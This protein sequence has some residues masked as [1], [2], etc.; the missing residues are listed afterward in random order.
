MLSTE[1]RNA[2]IATLQRFPDVLE[3]LVAGLTDEQLITPYMAGEWTVAQNIHHV[4]DSHM[5][6][7]IR[8]KLILTEDKPSLKPYNQED[9]AILPD[10][11]DSDISGSLAAIRGLHVRWAA[12]FAGLTESQWARVG[13]HG[14]LGEITPQDLVK[15]YAEHCEAHLDQ[16]T[17]TLAAR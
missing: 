3:A 10:A 12:V 6:S 1:Q 13:I 8:L 4:M 14:E 16:I 7:Y 9:W 17:R 15:Y 11:T 2:Y 5:H